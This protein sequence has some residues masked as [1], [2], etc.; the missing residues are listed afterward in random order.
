MLKPGMFATINLILQRDT[1]VLTLQKQNVLHDDKGNY[2]YEVNKDSV[3]QKK[4]IE[5]GIIENNTYELTSGLS[6]ND[7]V[8]TVGMELINDG[9]KVRIAKK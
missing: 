2:V 9:S 4:Y 7:K 1:N 5:V 8:V 6:D 3:A